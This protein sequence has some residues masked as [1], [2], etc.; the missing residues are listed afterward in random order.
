MR[1]N[2]THQRPRAADAK[3]RFSSRVE[4]YVRYRPAYPGGVLQC[5]EREC[6]LTPAWR[7][8]DIGSGT[9]ISSKLFLDYG[10]TVFAV[11]PNPDMRRAAERLLGSVPGF[12][13]EDGSAEAT[14]I[15]AG[16]VD[17][18][19]AAQAFHWF[20][21]AG[22]REEFQRIVRPEAAWR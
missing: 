11:E 6:G 1:Q 22:A 7:V 18:A 2:T 15:P 12:H 20:D 13:S 14:G 9:G 10:C 16:S 4:N 17:L 21:P 3:T 19:I 5:L 8:A